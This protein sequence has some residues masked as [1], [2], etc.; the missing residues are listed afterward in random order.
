MTVPELQD[1]RYKCFLCK[2]FVKCADLL[3]VKTITVSKFWLNTDSFGGH[4]GC[5]MFSASCTFCKYFD[6]VAIYCFDLLSQCLEFIALLN[7]IM[8]FVYSDFQLPCRGFNK[9][10]PRWKFQLGFSQFSRASRWHKCS[11]R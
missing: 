10:F 7:L 3:G 1:A 6:A 4:L 2:S 8:H 5:Y 9:P 11:M